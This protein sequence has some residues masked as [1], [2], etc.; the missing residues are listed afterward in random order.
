MRLDDHRGGPFL[1][2][3]PAVRRAGRG[4]AENESSTTRPPDGRPGN[5][6]ANL[7]LHY[8]LPRSVGLRLKLENLFNEQ[9][10]LFKGWPMPGISVYGAVDY[11]F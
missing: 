6:P 3:T 7:R 8:R 2:V 4:I 9:H 10:E 1:Q 5:V 11:S